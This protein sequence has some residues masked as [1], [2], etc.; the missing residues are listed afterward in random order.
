MIE[1]I[2]IYNA[3]VLF[4]VKC[5]LNV[6]LKLRIGTPVVCRG[7]KKMACVCVCVYMNIYIYMCV[8]VCVYIYIYM[9]I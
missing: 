4:P 2:I 5:S 6:H 7:L 3:A 8:C 9:Y 1:N